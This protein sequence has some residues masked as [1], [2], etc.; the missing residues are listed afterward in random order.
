MKLQDLAV[1]PQ[2][3]QLANVFE[4]YF[5]KS[6]TFESISKRQAH[7][8]L[9]KVR[10]LLSEHRSTPKFHVS[11]KN[12]AYLKLVMLEQVL[13]KKL[14]EEFPA[15]STGGV[16]TTGTTATAAPAAPQK[17]AAT[18]ATTQGINKI[19]DPKLKA[20]MTKSAAGQPLNSDE[21]KLVQGAAVAAVASESRRRTGRRLSE[22]EVQQA[23]VILASQ[24]MVDQVQK[25]IEQVTSLQFKDLP[26]L[27]DQI[28]N[29]IGYEQA[30]KFNADATAALGGMV[31]NLQ[32]S[33]IQLE[34]AMGT[35]TG[36]NPVVPGAD[37]MGAEM[38]G[39][40]DTTMP[41]DVGDELDDLAD[42][43]MDDE[44]DAPIK[45]SLGRERR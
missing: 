12:S 24:D 42:N 3:K 20:A 28:R 36:Q 15:T 21:Q 19:Q 35:V 29:E 34:G 23:Q 44:V 43:D 6:I 39:E 38:P 27:V 4:S 7:A 11:E 9:G 16:T 8:M 31:Q 2:T 45:T 14:R 25:M 18:A 5:G 30:T 26:A 41:G 10:G 33:K 17:A 1:L 40:L 13:T 37:E 32:Q 22:S